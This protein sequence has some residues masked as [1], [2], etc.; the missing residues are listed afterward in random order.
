LVDFIVELPEAHGYDAVMVMV[1][2][3]GKRA[4]FIPTH[5]T[6]TAQGSAELFLRNVWKLVERDDI[7]RLLE[8][9]DNPMEVNP[10][11]SVEIK[12][13]ELLRVQEIFYTIRE[14]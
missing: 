14:R 11:N 8:R 1:D 5:T 7:L 13:R 9:A 4:H 2:S 6:V 12:P 10:G 3:A